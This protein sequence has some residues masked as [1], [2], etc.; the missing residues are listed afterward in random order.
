MADYIPP[1]NEDAPKRFIDVG[2]HELIIA[3]AGVILAVLVHLSDMFT[4]LKITI[5]SYSASL[6]FSAAGQ[7]SHLL[8]MGQDLTL[9]G[10][11][12]PECTGYAGILR[13]HDC[14]VL[15]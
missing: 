4:P 13:L 2:T 8:Y 11:L 9:P 15:P 3:A 6:R 12:H 10:S 1:K 14:H 5:P 7:F